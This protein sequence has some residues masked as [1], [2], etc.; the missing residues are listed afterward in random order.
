V[1]A[2]LGAAY[3]FY[4]GPGALPFRSESVDYGIDT[5]QVLEPLIKRFNTEVRRLLQDGLLA[6]YIEREENLTTLRGRLSSRII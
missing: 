3:S 2:L 4:S 1:F 5:A 6:N